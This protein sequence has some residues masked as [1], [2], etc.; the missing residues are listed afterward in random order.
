MKRPTWATVVGILGIIFGS[1]GIIGSFQIMFMPQMLEWQKTIMADFHGEVPKEEVTNVEVG[2][3]QSENTPTSFGIFGSWE[4]MFTFPDWFKQWCIV[5]GVIKLLISAIILYASIGLLQ[6]KKS[7]IG[8]FCFA[9]I[10]NILYGIGSAIVAVTS[11]SFIAASMMMG[12]MFEGVIDFVL[13]VV[14]MSSSKEAFTVGEK[15]NSDV[16]EMGN[17]Q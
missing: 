5:S 12:S 6:L 11:L 3:E 13:L 17:N 10:A 9:S 2:V 4:E 1:M 15:L 7:A 16:Y 14:V 8:I